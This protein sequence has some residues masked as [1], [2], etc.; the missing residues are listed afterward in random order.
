MLC[1]LRVVW[2]NRRVGVCLAGEGEA[3]F[4]DFK[5]FNSSS[6]T[7]VDIVSVFL[8]FGEFGCDLII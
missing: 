4:K 8:K 2:I 7:V 3:F 6:F 5:S 1:E